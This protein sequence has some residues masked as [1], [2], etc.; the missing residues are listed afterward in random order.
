MKKYL[1]IDRLKKSLFLFELTNLHTCVARG[2]RNFISPTNDFV[3]VM[4]VE[5]YLGSQQYFFNFLVNP[6]Y[7]YDLRVRRLF[8]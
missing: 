1:R 3:I 8:T 6:I 7:C 2:D 5:I 4:Q